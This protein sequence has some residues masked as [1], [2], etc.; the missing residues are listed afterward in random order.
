MIAQWNS[1][2]VELHLIDFTAAVLNQLPTLIS[3]FPS[4]MVCTY[5]HHKKTMAFNCRI[6]FQ[7]LGIQYIY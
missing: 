1:K 5:V 6:L 2:Y 7:K 4:Y 3:H